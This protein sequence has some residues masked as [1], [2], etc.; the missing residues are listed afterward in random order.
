MDNEIYK[1]KALLNGY[2]ND[3]EE[4][5][6]IIGCLVFRG[7][8]VPCVTDDGEL[9]WEVNPYTIC[10][11]TGIKVKDKYL[12]EYDLVEY[13]T[14][15]EKGIAIVVFD[16]LQKRYRLQSNIDYSGK[17]D[18]D[19]YN[20]KIIGNV[21]VYEKDM[22]KFEKYSKEEN[23]KHVPQTTSHTTSGDRFKKRCQKEALRGVGVRGV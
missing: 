18:I 3:D 22:K 5:K 12:Y 21:M 23:K 17:I 14:A 20:L 4:E 1:V 15:F 13:S 9:F 19:K 10:R 2:A 6:E 7:G 11:N 16:E 8:E